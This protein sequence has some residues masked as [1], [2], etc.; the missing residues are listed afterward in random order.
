MATGNKAI[1][2]KISYISFMVTEFAEA[3]K[4]NK[5][6]AYLYFKQYGG[7]DFMFRHWWAMHTDDAYYG[8]R[9]LYQV[10]RKMEDY[11][12]HILRQLHRN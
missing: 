1:R 3:F 4:M 2:N 12:E 8:L 9:D 6:A 10:C 11:D 5:P 7:I